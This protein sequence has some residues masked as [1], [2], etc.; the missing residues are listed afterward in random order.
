[1]KNE[2]SEMRKDISRI[3]ISDQSVGYQIVYAVTGGP[4]ES[5]GLKNPVQA[6]VAGSVLIN[7]R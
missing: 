2:K 5:V 4:R 6:G 3:G 1:M 7:W